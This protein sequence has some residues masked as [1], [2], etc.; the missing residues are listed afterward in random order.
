[1]NLPR[2]AKMSFLVFVCFVVSSR[3]LS[4]QS[5]KVPYVSVSPTNGP[6]WI[7]KEARLFNKY[8]LPDVQLIYIPGG[9]VIIQSMIAGEANIA[10]MAPPAALAAWVKGADFAVV[11]SAVNR[12]LETVVTPAHIKSPKD[13]KGKKVGIGRY[14]S[15]TDAA[16]REALRYYSLVPDKEVTVIQAGAEGSRLAALIAGALDGAMLS[17]AERIQAEKLGFHVVIDFSKLPLEFPNN[18]IIVRKDF[19]RNNREAVKRFL[20]AWIEGIKIFKTEPELSLKVLGKYLR[21]KDQ[22]VLAESYKPYP[23]VFDRVPFPKREGFVFAL[24]RIAKELPEAGK[25]SADNFIDNSIV[26]ELEKEGFIRDL[27]SE[28]GK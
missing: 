28:K 14:G 2:A 1:M 23:P 5:L 22:E 12:L 8:N 25:M 13:L 6:L 21:V 24:D 3:T 11:G 26:Q 19:V 16:F 18:G 20:K 15:L 17:G 10:N 27:Y 7:A 9:T 4:A